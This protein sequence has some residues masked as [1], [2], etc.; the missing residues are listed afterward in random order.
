MEQYPDKGIVDRRAQAFHRVLLI[1]SC[2]L[3]AAGAAFSLSGSFWLGGFGL[4][5]W[6]GLRGFFLSMRVA[7]VDWMPHSNAWHTD[8]SCSEDTTESTISDQE[9]PQHVHLAQDWAEQREEVAPPAVQEVSGLLPDPATTTRPADVPRPMA[10][11]KTS[12]A[13]AQQSEMSTKALRMRIGN[14]RL[15]MALMDPES[16]E[17][18]RRERE[19]ERDAK[20]LVEVEKEEAKDTHTLQRL[21]PKLQPTQMKSVTPSGGLV[22]AVGDIVSHTRF[23]SGIVVTVDKTG[24]ATIDFDEFGYKTLA[25]IPPF[26]RHFT[27]LSRWEAAAGAVEF[28]SRV[29]AAVPTGTTQSDES[30][31][32]VS[33]EKLDRDFPGRQ[34]L[35]G[36]WQ[37]GW[38]LD[39]HTLSSIPL[40][41]GRFE[42]IRPVL[43]E[44][45]HQLKYHSD[46]EAIE[47]LAAAVSSFIRIQWG[48]LPLAAIIP[49]PPSNWSRPLQP[50]S[51]IVRRVGQETG[52]VVMERYLRKIKATPSLKDIESPEERCRILSGAFQIW[53]RSLTGKHILLFDDLYRSG[54]TL[55]AA[56]DVLIE[57]GG[58][59]RQ[60][61]HVLTITKTR[62]RR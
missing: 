35:D 38:A 42:T 45:L 18:R 26:D 57:Q 28:T 29:R 55:R 23:G 32:L 36:N 13:K 4:L 14:N 31:G 8:A 1:L 56:T 27:L 48:Q 12:A 25:T 21:A 6:W 61:I 62:S 43:G 44:K 15:E 46:A 16:I 59:T 3:I 17:Y 9:T 5:L 52:I 34:R 39:L 30:K 22:F 10:Q 7:N 20:L 40:G 47:V 2:L 24:L 41:D 53:D 50:V 37:D 51:A 19:V 60:C 33:W 49:I 54:A 11:A 58:L